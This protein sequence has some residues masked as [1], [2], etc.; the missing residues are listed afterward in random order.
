MGAPPKGT[1]VQ[2]VQKLARVGT[3]F[4]D[5]DLAEEETA[6]LEGPLASLMRSEGYT[7]RDCRNIRSKLT[8]IRSTVKN[9]PPTSNPT[10]HY[11]NDLPRLAAP[12][13]PAGER[14]LI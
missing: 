6:V 7:N 8:D 14:L 12:Y 10:F 3:Q 1:D 9:R 4:T 2:W 13:V 11:Y 5:F